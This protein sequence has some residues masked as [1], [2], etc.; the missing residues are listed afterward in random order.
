MV[1]LLGEQE[2]WRSGDIDRRSK[3][4]PFGE[5]CKEA[6]QTGERLRDINRQL[7]RADG[8]VRVVC[9]SAT[10]IVIS[11]KSETGCLITIRDQTEA[12]AFEHELWRS[13]NHD[14]L[15]G[16]Y[17]R[18]FAD[19][20]LNHEIEQASA[21]GEPLS[22][23]LFDIDAFKAVNDQFGHDAGD[24]VLRQL[25]ALV[26][27]RVR[28]E[29][30]FVRWGGEEFAVLLPGTGLAGSTV[31]AEGIREVIKATPFGNVGSVWISAGLAE[32]SPNETARDWFRRA[33]DLLYIA[34][35]AGGDCV[36]AGVTADAGDIESH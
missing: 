2:P 9:L 6:M 17:N 1:E 30:Y 8:T 3:S 34:K 26:Q 14:V 29:D 31:L 12:W 7:R 27:R 20:I 19:E 13:A 24:E 35:S 22:L 11:E 25:S 5:Q 32:Y 28:T 10:P 15:T 21:H 4:Q 18:R 36:R 16:T 23:I 33:D